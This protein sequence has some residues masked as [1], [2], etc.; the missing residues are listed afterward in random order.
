[1]CLK[2]GQLKKSKSEIK[3]RAHPD[4]QCMRVI[5]NNK[6]TVQKRAVILFY[7]VHVKLCSRVDRME[8]AW[9]YQRRHSPNF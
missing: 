7:Y 1:M 3:H 5:V 4:S 2:T 8:K 9:W 6:H